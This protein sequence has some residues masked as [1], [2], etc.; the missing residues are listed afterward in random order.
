[1]TEA[2]G[3][4]GGTFDPVH[5]G[6]LMAA[7]FARSEFKLAKVLLMLA[8]RPPHKQEELI[9]DEEH[10]LEMLKLAIGDNKLLEVSSLELNRPG[11]SYTIDT[12]KYFREHFPEKKIYFIMGSDALFTMHTWKQVNELSQLCKFI[13]VTRPGYLLK[14]D[15]P[16]YARLPSGLWDNISYL[17]IPGFDFS[18]TDI[19]KRVSQDKPIKY[20]VPPKVEQY[21]RHHGLYREMGKEDA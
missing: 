9:L 14:K 6:H 20:L 18:S 5:Y 7:E 1:M 19:R 10:R 8:A 17:E 3:I 21:I 16:Q 13:V 2:T 4:M 11:R 12:I 15:D